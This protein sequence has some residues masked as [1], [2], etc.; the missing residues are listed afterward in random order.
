MG[1]YTGGKSH[2]G[3]Y[4]LRL[5]TG[6]RTFTLDLEMGRQNGIRSRG[7]GACIGPLAL[8]YYVRT[9][10]QRAALPSSTCCAAS[11]N[12]LQPTMGWPAYVLP[13]FILRRAPSLHCS[14]EENFADA[15]Q[16]AAHQVRS[17]GHGG[18]PLRRRRPMALASLRFHFRS[19]QRSRNGLPGRCKKQTERDRHLSC[20]NVD[21]A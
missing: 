14:I 5:T 1:V 4:N 19:A 18:G 12:D 17:I 16:S 21:G 15:E 2:T 11:S 13:S 6:G 20:L 7:Y 9:T 10:K 3:T 8:A